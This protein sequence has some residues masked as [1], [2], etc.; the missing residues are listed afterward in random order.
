MIGQW[1]LG[2]HGHVIHSVAARQHPSVYNGVGRHASYTPPSFPTFTHDVLLLPASTSPCP[3]LIPSH[4][5]DT[6]GAR[7]ADGRGGR[8]PPHSTG[9]SPPRP[10]NVLLGLLI[11]AVVIGVAIVARPPRYADTREF[12]SGVV[13]SSRGADSEGGD[14]GGT[15]FPDPAS[16]VDADLTDLTRI[17]VDIPSV[18]GSEGPLGRWMSAALAARGWGVATQAVAPL[19]GSSGG[20]RFNVVAVWRGVGA[21]GV[22]AWA[23]ATA[24]DDDEGGAA[25]TA[26]N[27]QAAAAAAA[28]SAAAGNARGSHGQGGLSA[29]EMGGITVLLST[30]LDTV[31]PWYA[32]SFSADGVLR[33]RGVVDAKGLA[34]AMVIAAERLGRGG[35][36]APGTVGLLLVCG[37][38]TDHGGM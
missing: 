6:A 16:V 21:G 30:H 35:G 27:I 2:D 33:G 25:N 20:E 24:E 31:G 5:M 32:A 12:D 18:S 13:G 10:A 34:A 4:P 7:A 37:E 38:E 36:A 8:R 22:T 19:E 29:A 23:P 9:E 26:A 11:A 14:G 28:D 1:L 17:L 15:T 3:Y